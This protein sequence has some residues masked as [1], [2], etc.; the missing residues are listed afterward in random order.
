LR[1][2]TQQKIAE[3]IQK[4]TEERY[5]QIVETAQEGVMV[6]DEKGIILFVNNY[7]AN[8]VKE[9]KENIVGKPVLSFFNSEQQKTIGGYFENRKEGISENYELSLVI[10]N[11]T[12]K[13]LSVAST[14]L[15]KY[16]IHIGALSMISDITE[17]KNAETALIKTNKLYDALGRVTKL[18]VNLTTQKELLEEACSIIVEYSTDLQLA[19][20]GKHNNDE[21]IVEVKAAFGESV[22]FTTQLQ[23]KLKKPQA[24]QNEIERAINTGLY[25]ICNDYY[26]DANTILWQDIARSYGFAAF[27]LFPLK[28]NGSVWGTLNVYAST[29]NYFQESEV[30]LI[31]KI[32]EVISIG[33][34]K[35]E[36]EEIKRKKEQEILAAK[37][38]WERTFN[39]IPDYIAILDNNHNIVRANMAMADLVHQST[40]SIIGQKC[41]TLMHGTDCPIGNCPHSALMEDGR[42]HNANLYEQ[43]FDAHLD[44]TTSPIFDKDGNILGSVHIA[45][46][47]TEQK[48]A[49]Q[50][51]KQLADINEYSKSF[52]GIANADNTILYMN[53]EM[54][55]VLGYENE[56]DLSAVYVN[57][58]LTT[59]SESVFQEI[60]IPSLMKDGI[61]VGE[62][63]WRR[64]DNS[65]LPVYMVAMTHKDTS[66][67]I[68]YISCTA[69]DISELKKKEDELRSLTQ[70]LLN[71]R[72]EE[73]KAI[74]KE[75]HDDLGQNLTA[76]KLDVTWIS[77]HID[78][79]K[80]M[81]QERLLKLE[82]V[83]GETV[84][85]SRRLYNNLYP[86]M[87]DEIGLSGAIK[88]HANTYLK[89]SDIDFE[90][91]TN[92]DREVIPELHDIF[93]VLYRV[94][95][96]CITNVLRY[97]KAD[98]VIV[99]LYKF[100]NNI[101]LIIQ[102]DG[103]GFEINNVDTKLHHGLL[104]MRERVYALKGNI[105]LYSAI[106]KGT[107]TTVIIPI[108]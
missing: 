47:I 83:T 53:Q 30:S 11:G 23:I 6:R 37:E 16:G 33:I 38:E 45:R 34:A 84:S 81:I 56:K 60:S 108:S 87:L 70:N 69:I 58:F 54:K 57:D 22:H 78:G 48:K 43:K 68:E 28:L 15:S 99:E 98:T 26:N 79:D 59:K 18:L 107:K 31:E 100:E 105:T 12:T 14:P 65:V 24:E 62:A 104:G 92:L 51:I 91:Q 96:E 40:H 64:K 39:S 97:A 19:W 46:D 17:K 2:I 75:L 27:A 55:K 80:A 8:M 25:Y 52:V 72:E 101:S 71:A 49:E 13:V 4:E 89:P 102:D 20:I 106:G 3:L 63:E 61:W 21:N 7:F 44:V 67:N 85:T 88:W 9:K 77:T 10:P 29:K 42:W 35:L 86:Q 32:A 74:A 103:I 76:L 41:Y 1:D 82:Q 95:Q 94:Y 93:L 5:K 50:K 73:R 66:E 90:L 36:D